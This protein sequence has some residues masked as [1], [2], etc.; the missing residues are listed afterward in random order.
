MLKNSI[1][2]LMCVIY[3]FVKYSFFFKFKYIFLHGT[4]YLFSKHFNLS[5]NEH[6]LIL[7]VKERLHNN[8]K[9]FKLKVDKH[10][11]KRQNNNIICYDEEHH[12]CQNQ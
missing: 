11:I 8:N 10:F 1:G 3:E 5:I 9:N 2:S 7:T 4:I 6:Y 12:R